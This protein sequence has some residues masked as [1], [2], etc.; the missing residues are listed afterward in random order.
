MCEV[1]GV[2]GFFGFYF[3][4]CADVVGYGVV[5]FVCPLYEFVYVGVW[6]FPVAV[7]GVPFDA[8]YG[9]EVVDL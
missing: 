2:L 8:G 4:L 7:V 9:F 1:V 6:G 3:C 5:V